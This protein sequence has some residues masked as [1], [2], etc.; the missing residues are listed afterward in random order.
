MYKL[1]LSGFN[2]SNP[3]LDWLFNYCHLQIV[4][5]ESLVLNQ[6][7]LTNLFKVLL[8]LNKKTH[9]KSLESLRYLNSEIIWYRKSAAK[10][11]CRKVSD[12]TKKDL[13]RCFL[14]LFKLD[15]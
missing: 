8:K 4:Q 12:H 13:I 15:C 14:L 7:N 10:I 11:D 1:S 3:S 2:G 5:V 9:R 6:E